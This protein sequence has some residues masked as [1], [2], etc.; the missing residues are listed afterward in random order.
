MPQRKRILCQVVWLALLPLALGCQGR[1]APQG[2]TE[3]VAASSGSAAE[4]N[5]STLPTG[6]PADSWFACYQQ[7]AKIGQMHVNVRP[8]TLDGQPMLAVQS[9]TQITLRRGK[10]I[11]QLQIQLSSKES[12]SGTLYE[13]GGQ[14]NLSNQPQRYPDK[15]A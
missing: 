14:V 13:F 15:R 7:G 8:T 9:S 1:A 10:D 3:A 4:D 5:A 2:S 11:N 12:P 6:L